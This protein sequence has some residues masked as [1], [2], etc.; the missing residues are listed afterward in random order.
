[1]L[2]RVACSISELRRR[3]ALVHGDMAPS[4]VLNR[5]RRAGVGDNKKEKKEE[6]KEELHG[7]VYIYLI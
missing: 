4:S 3:R 1:M 2:A 5:V 7:A 6:K